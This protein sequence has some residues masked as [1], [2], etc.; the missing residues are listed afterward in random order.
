MITNPSSTTVGFPLILCD[1]G[2]AS[3]V[4][5]DI[6]SIDVGQCFYATS[7]AKTAASSSTISQGHCAEQIKAKTTLSAS[8]DGNRSIAAAL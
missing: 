7:I 1:C 6:S 8:I 4:S 2:A 3:I 5:S